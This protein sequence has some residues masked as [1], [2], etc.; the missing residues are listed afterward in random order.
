MLDSMESELDFEKELDEVRAGSVH[1]YQTARHSGYSATAVA[2][3]QYS[4]RDIHSAK[5]G[6]ILDQDEDF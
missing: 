2:G 4:S 3:G 1:N 6:L 5:N